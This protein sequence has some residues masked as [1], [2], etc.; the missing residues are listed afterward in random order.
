MNSVE[1]F[2][3]THICPFSQGVSLKQMLIKAQLQFLTGI[4]PAPQTTS[5]A[6]S[7]Q[8]CRE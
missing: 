1:L 8:T 4:S 3:R 6:V 5:Q 7:T 2:P